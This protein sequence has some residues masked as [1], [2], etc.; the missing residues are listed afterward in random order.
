MS[1][2]FGGYAAKHNGLSSYTK[3]GITAVPGRRPATLWKLKAVVSPYRIAIIF[4]NSVMR[5][6]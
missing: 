5:I 2:Q 4:W 3:A 1:H 6:A